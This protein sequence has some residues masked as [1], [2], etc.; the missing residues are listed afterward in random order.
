M[1][2]YICYNINTIESRSLTTNTALFL[3]LKHRGHCYVGRACPKERVMPMSPA[4][5]WAIRG[6]GALVVLVLIAVVWTAIKRS[7]RPATAAN[8]EMQPAQTATLP[9][10]PVAPATPPTT[11]PSA[12]TTAPAA[13]AG[14]TTVNN[15]NVVNVYPPASPAHAATPPTIVQQSPPLSRKQIEGLIS[16]LDDKIRKDEL[17]LRMQ[18]INAMKENDTGVKMLRDDMVAEMTKNLKKDR[19]RRKEWSAQLER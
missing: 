15:N 13:P 17:N 9:S 4:K 14:P 8:A 16:E 3:M 19:E 1:A 18:T 10:A 2:T 12:P 7:G 5:K 11:P 6:I